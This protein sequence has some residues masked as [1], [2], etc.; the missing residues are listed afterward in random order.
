VAW[1]FLCVA[2]DVFGVLGVAHPELFPSAWFEFVTSG[3][4]RIG[5]FM[6]LLI[7]C[8]AVAFVAPPPS[9]EDAP[10]PGRREAGDETSF[11]VWSVSSVSCLVLVI[12]AVL[13]LSDHEKRDDILGYV[14]VLGGGPFL[15][16]GSH[17]WLVAR[18][19]DTARG[20]LNGLL[21]VLTGE[22]VL[23][24][25]SPS[26]R[27]EAIGAYAVALWIGVALAWSSAPLARRLAEGRIAR[28]ADGV[29]V[30]LPAL[31]LLLGATFH[32]AARD[33][34][35]R[36]LGGSRAFYVGAASGLG[37]AVFL[38]ARSSGAPSIDASRG[39][40]WI[41]VA[42]CA[43]CGLLFLDVNLGID[44]LHYSAFL[45]PANAVLHGRVP[46]VTVQCQYG[47]SYLVYAVAFASP[48][49]RSFA[50]AALVTG[51]VNV[52]CYTGF[53]LSLR[54]LTRS[55]VLWLALGATCLLFFQDILGYDLNGT[56]S[57]CGLR[58]FPI[59]AL[60]LAL[61]S[62]P[63][64]RAFTVWSVAAAVLCALW[65]IEAFAFGL[66]VHAAFL[67]VRSA[68]RGESWRIV[69][70]LVGRVVSLS[71]LTHALLSVT[72]RVWAG[73][74]PH[75]RDYLGMIGAYLDEYRMG[76]LVALD[77]QNLSWVPVA[78]GY[79]VVI[80]VTI[81]GVLATRATPLAPGAADE[82]ARSFLVAALGTALF[83]IFAA[84]ASWA[85]LVVVIFPFFLLALALCDRGLA[86]PAWRA[87]TSWALLVALPLLGGTT[88][89]TLPDDPGAVATNTGIGRALVSDPPSILRALRRVRTPGLES[90]ERHQ[91]FNAWSGPYDSP[92][93]RDGFAALARWAPRESEVLLF[94][95]YNTAFL[96]LSGRAHRYPIS[97]PEND[98]LSHSLAERILNAPVALH[99]GEP[100]I[101]SVGREEI[102][103]IL[104]R[105]LLRIA[106]KWRLRPLER[107]KD[108]AVYELEARPSGDP[109]PETVER[110]LTEVP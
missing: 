45:G 61:L 67:A 2:L 50:G 35:A 46:F 21:L 8:L 73:E 56:P 27:P 93:L 23:L 11:V 12:A 41:G 29:V 109:P 55:W 47:L 60:A 30:L 91:V 24:W 79:V 31:L 49:P 44:T 62:L 15:A 97:N 80:A 89:A 84:R 63:E 26:P 105:L 36:W 10:S 68:L 52:A 69:G 59:Y 98:E 92:L 96:F 20:I 88:L 1:A 95:P 9:P 90:D 104:E 38:V 18:R 14:V 32:P 87:S 72:I 65:S 17:R 107:G 110:A 94:T 75:Y 78:L 108:V 37:V 66:A 101:V 70:R 64:D 7:G 86:S 54:R 81:R 71:L 6:Q 22:A 28:L 51:A 106:E 5:I 34:L 85:L 76:W 3:H 13:G 57:V 83:A 102:R 103:P 43:L 58:F 74:W 48:L 19:R 82:R 100:V 53:L 4:I 42:L 39:A 99:A 77:P 16:F 40:G 33:Q 25:I